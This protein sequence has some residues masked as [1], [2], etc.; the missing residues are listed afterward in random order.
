[1]PDEECRK[2]LHRSDE[3]T[4]ITEFI[5]GDCEGRKKFT[6]GIELMKWAKG[7]DFNVGEVKYARGKDSYDC[8]LSSADT[9]TLVVEVKSRDYPMS[10]FQKDGWEIEE[11]KVNLL[12]EKYG[13]KDPE[14]RTIKTL[15]AFTMTDGMA[16]WDVNSHKSK[17]MSKLKAPYQAK[18]TDEQISTPQYFYD[19]KDVL[20]KVRFNAV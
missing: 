19:L 12:K 5:R 9:I 15:V 18:E 20:W 11:T 8:Y 4:P 6:I 17:G 14:G 10:A 1:M 2:Y 16:I 3:N 13:K 7:K